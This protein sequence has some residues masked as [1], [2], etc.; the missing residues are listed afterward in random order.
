M[1]YFLTLWTAL[2]LLTAGVFGQALSLDQKRS[3]IVRVALAEVGVVERG[4]NA[5]A[6]VEAYQRS[7]GLTKGQPYCAAFVYWCGL[8]ALG[9]ANP[10]PRSGWSPD[11]VRKPTWT[12]SS[13]GEVSPGDAGG[14]FSAAKGRIYHT[15]IIRER[16][17][18]WFYTIEGNTSSGASGSQNE[19][20]GVYARMR[21]VGSVRAA[22]D[23]FRR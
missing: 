23:W 20:E 11:F 6:R 18:I 14:L 19:G 21:P 3:A 5:G 7:A 15:F 1:R 22:R 13:G 12:A 4:F 2:T 9:P 10:Y 16:R 17:G 8:T